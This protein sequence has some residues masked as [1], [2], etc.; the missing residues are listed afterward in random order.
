MLTTVDKY[1]IFILPTTVGN[2]KEKIHLSSLEMINILSKQ[3]AN[4]NDIK[5]LASCGRDN[6]IRIRNEISSQIKQQGKN[7]P[8]SKQKLVPMMSV[9]SYLDLNLE[10]IYLMAQK[11]KNLNYSKQ[12]IKL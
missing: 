1:V 5:N 12:K 3:W 11:E 7:L 8:I 9:I 10:H 6:A 4:I 2:R